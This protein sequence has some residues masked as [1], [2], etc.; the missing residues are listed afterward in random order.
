MNAMSFPTVAPED[1]TPAEVESAAK[2]LGLKTVTA[3]S[4][5]AHRIL[6]SHLAEI[7]VASVGRGVYLSTLESAQ[8]AMAK[9]EELMEVYEHDPD[10]VTKL[11]NSQA[12]FCSVT[13]AAAKGI[14]EAGDP[15]KSAFDGPALPPP[16][17][18][19]IFV[20][21]DNVSVSSQ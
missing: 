14:I 5:R 15:Q 21:G 7:G 2:V 4:I 9:I 18:T 8:R 11:L 3:D 12:K 20:R 17:P 10:T 1:V 16:P 19:Q 6:G 13:V